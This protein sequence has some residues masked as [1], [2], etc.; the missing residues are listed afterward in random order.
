LAQKATLA[1]L[2]TGMILTNFDL[3]VKMVI[4]AARN[5]MMKAIPT[6]SVTTDFYFAMLFKLS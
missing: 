4:I 5:P 3:L 1:I 6:I 2:R